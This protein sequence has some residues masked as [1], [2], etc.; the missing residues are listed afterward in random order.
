MNCPKCV[1]DNPDVALFCGKCGTSL[2][3][4]TARGMG[5]ASSHLPMVSFM[6]AIKLGFSNYFKFTGRS[7]RAEYW[8]WVLFFVVAS[9][10]LGLIISS[11][12]DLSPSV[13]YF[14]GPGELLLLGTLIPWLALGSRRL[15][16]INRTGWWQLMW[17]GFPFIIPPIVL[18]VC[19][20]KQGD[21][22]PNKYG[23]DPRR[24]ATQPPDVTS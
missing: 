12:R 7:T 16:D 11:I 15:H 18:M 24:A 19:A 21:A 3:A 17:L 1:T 9:A 2:R 20:I 5:T 22:N 6:R 13:T 10:G 4:S 23:T 8:W 14:V